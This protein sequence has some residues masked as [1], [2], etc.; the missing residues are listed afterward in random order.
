MV[1]VCDPGYQQ[2]AGKGYPPYPQHQPYGGY[3]KEVEQTTCFNAPEVRNT[4]YSKVSNKRTVCNKR[5]G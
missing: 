2:Y 3:C 5:T 1:T 4:L